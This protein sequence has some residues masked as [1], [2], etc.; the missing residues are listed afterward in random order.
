LRKLLIS[1]RKD[2]LYSDFLKRI[3]LKAIQLLGSDSLYI[4]FNKADAIIYQIIEDDLNKEFPEKEIIIKNSDLK[5]D[6]GVIIESQDGKELVE[7]TFRCFLDGIKEEIAID[8]NHR[9]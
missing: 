1:Y 5:I 3:I 8:I 9:I 6:G 7:N 4:N 2:P